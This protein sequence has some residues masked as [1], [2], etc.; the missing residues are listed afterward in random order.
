[1]QSLK[2]LVAKLMLKEN[3]RGI[4]R[5]SLLILL[6]LSACSPV[7]PVEVPAAPTAVPVTPTSIPATSTVEATEAPTSTPEETAV[8]PYYLSLATKPE[9]DP[10]TI[11]GVTAQI[12]WAYADESRVAL[13]YTISGLDWPDG[14]PWDAMS[15]QVTSSKIKDLG[16]GGGGWNSVPASHGVIAGSSDLLLI[17]GALDSAKYPNVD[18]RVDIPVKDP[19]PVGTFRFKF[20]VPVTKGIRIE[21][22][23]QTV[24]AND[25]SMTLKTLVF[26]PSRAEALICFQMPSQ[27]D[28]GLTASKLTVGGKEYPF[29]GGGL[30]PGTDG[31]NFRLDDTDRCSTVGFNIAYDAAATSVTLTVPKL[32][33]STPEVMEKE[34]VERANKRLADA[35]IEFDY[36]NVDHG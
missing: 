14:T 6:L 34:R 36:E 20:I 2:L 11:N 32:L 25:V 24:V 29:S 12:D 15:V 23:D 16:F 30:M 21:N 26:N 33:A 3:S 4:A 5:I 9:I 10:Q 18:L 28:W 7:T 8:Y 19:S 31:K 13:H 35:G 1:M 17:D 27:V 22:I